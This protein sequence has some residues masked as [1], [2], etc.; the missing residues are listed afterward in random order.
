MIR[1]FLWYGFLVF[2]VGLLGFAQEIQRTAP[3]IVE[4]SNT[5]G[6]SLA[7]SAAEVDGRIFTLE[8]VDR[9]I[10]R[11]LQDLEERKYQ[12]RRAALEQ[13]IN[14][15]LLE[16]AAK[17]DGVTIPSFILSR[18]PA[19]SESDVEATY[20]GNKDHLPA[21]T[22]YAVKEQIRES[23][24]KEAKQR[25]YRDTIRELRSRAEVRVFLRRPTIAPDLFS[26]LVGS[27]VG[28][29]AAPIR[30]VVF[31][32]YQC[33]FCRK[34]Q[35]TV[36]TLL[37]KYDGKIQLVHKV[38]IPKDNPTSVLM[39]KAAL[40]ADEQQAFWKYHHSLFAEGAV[41]S[42]Q[43][44]SDRASAMGLDRMPFDSCLA[45]DELNSILE[46]DRKDAALVGARGTPFFLLNGQVFRGM[47]PLEEFDQAISQ[48]LPGYSMERKVRTANRQEEQ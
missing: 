44:L 47:Q 15:L 34:S 43:W 41:G 22:D 16:E 45:S 19:V 21:D 9:T 35:D 26:T 13:R 12:L 36:N 1:T 24:Q 7:T 46:R 3:S 23:L 4:G 31:S 20:R 5:V 8:E 38:L 32:D 29:D 40:C 33:G 48:H 39:A 28:P 14:Q 2:A 42:V 11:Q 18:M 6:S 17:S 25:A 27:S 10:A 37:S 30:L